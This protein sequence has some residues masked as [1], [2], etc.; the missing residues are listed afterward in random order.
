MVRLGELRLKPLRSGGAER[1]PA[2]RSAKQEDDKSKSQEELTPATTPAPRQWE[3]V[4][5]EAPTTIQQDMNQEM[6][7]L[8][9]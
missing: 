6:G 7:M 8:T 3:E 2:H 1:C 4:F 9:L 5:A